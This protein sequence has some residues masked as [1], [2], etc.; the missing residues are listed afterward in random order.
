[1]N[2]EQKTNM[3]VLKVVATFILMVMLYMIATLR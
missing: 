3:T 2:L 1:M